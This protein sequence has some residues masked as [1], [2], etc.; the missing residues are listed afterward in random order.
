M[1][2]AAIIIAFNNADL[3]IKQKAALSKFLTDAHDV[4]VIDNSNN[5]Q[6]SAAIRYHA[7]RTGCAYVRH[8]A[9]T[10]NHSHSHAQAAMHAVR[11]ISPQHYSN[12]LLLDHDCFAVQPF[13]VPAVLDGK[14]MGGMLQVR[15]AVHYLWPGCLMWDAKAIAVDEID[16]L[17]DAAHGLDTGGGLHKLMQARGMDSF[18]LFDEVHVSNPLFGKSF[19]NFYSSINDGMFMH[20][21]NA[22]N[23]ANASDDAERLNTLY[24]ILDGKINAST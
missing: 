21:L 20:F 6:A 16:L 11:T 18:R 2:T 15:G 1:K 10:H 4:I 3:I 14:V 23:W 7:H 5:E 9:T 19:Y 12:M 8:I 22:S 13:S 17:P 24:M